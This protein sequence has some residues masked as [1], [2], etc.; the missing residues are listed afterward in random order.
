[1]GVLNIAVAFNAVAKKNDG[2][3]RLLSEEMLKHKIDTPLRICHFLAQLSHESSGFT[4]T[5]ENLNYSAEGLLKTF[6]KYFKNGLEKKYERNPE[7]IASRV[8]ANR[9]GNSDEASKE[10][11]KYRGRGFIQITGKD[12]Y[13]KYSQLIFRDNRLVNNPDLA[14]EVE[15]A[16][17]V[18]CHFWSQNNCNFFADKDDIKGLT[19]RIN[20]GTTGLSHREELVNSSKKAV[21]I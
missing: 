10:G 18:A 19:K 6:P 8:Y 20:G 5:L 7:A 16:C 12:N 2:I 14:L 3:L 4:R 11:W 13:I 15:I 1:M 9:I 21:G 17:K